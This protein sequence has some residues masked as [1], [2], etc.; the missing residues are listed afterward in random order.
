M[1]KNCKDNFKSDCRAKYVEINEQ[2][3]E[4][5]KMISILEEKKLEVENELHRLK[6]EKAKVEKKHLLKYILGKL[7]NGESI[8]WFFSKNW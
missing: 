3:K 7:Q 5:D 4:Y 2:I 1:R 6:K 8:R